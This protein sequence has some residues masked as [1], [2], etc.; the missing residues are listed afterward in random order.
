MTPKDELPMMIAATAAI[1]FT[2]GAAYYTFEPL[3]EPPQPAAPQV[4]V[5]EVPAAPI[6][7]TNQPS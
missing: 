3:T 6:R 5:A 2:M 4:P 1:L 7:A